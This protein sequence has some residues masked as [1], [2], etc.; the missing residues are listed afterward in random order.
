M[1]LNKQMDLDLNSFRVEQYIAYMQI[2]NEKAE[3]NFV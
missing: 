2:N 1:S 3:I